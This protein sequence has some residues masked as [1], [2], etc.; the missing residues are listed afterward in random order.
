MAQNKKNHHDDEGMS[1]FSFSNSDVFND[2]EPQQYQQDQQHQ[3]PRQDIRLGSMSSDNSSNYSSVPVSVSQYSPQ[4]TPYNSVFHT[5][6]PSNDFKGF[7]PPVPP[8][9]LEKQP[10]DSYMS[11]F[12]Q[13]SDK[14]NNEVAEQV[15][16][17]AVNKEENPAVKYNDN[18]NQTSPKQYISQSHSPSQTNYYHEHKGSL[19]EQPDTDE[20]ESVFSKDGSIKL[21]KL[22]TQAPNLNKA[23][24]PTLSYQTNVEGSVPPRSTRRPRS[25]IVVT[26]NELAKDIDNFKKNRHSKRHSKRFSLSISDDLDKLMESANSISFNSDNS[27]NERNN[28]KDLHSINKGKQSINEDENDDEKTK[29]NKTLLSSNSSSKNI[30][31]L[32]DKQSIDKR[33]DISTIQENSDTEQI[34]SINKKSLDSLNS[35]APYLSKRTEV[36]SDQSSD[37]Y[38]TADNENMTSRASES[39]DS[40]A[41]TNTNI[42][43][44]TNSRSRP[45]L[46]PRPSFDNIQKARKLSNQVQAK[47]Q[48]S[49]T[50]SFES[51]GSISRSSSLNYHETSQDSPRTLILPKREDS[52]ISSNKDKFVDPDVTISQPQSRVVSQPQIFDSTEVEPNQINESELRNINET[53]SKN[54]QSQFELDRLNKRTSTQFATTAPLLEENEN[55][56]EN[57]QEEE[58]EE[59]QGADSNKKT[60]TIDEN[61][62]EGNTVD[63]NVVDEKEIIDELKDQSF[64]HPTQSS[65]QAGPTA[66]GDP[67]DEYYDIGS[68]IIVKQPSRGKLVKESTRHHKKNKPKRAKSKRI[69]RDSANSHNHNTVATGANLKP[70]SYHTLINLLESINGTIIGEEFNQLNLPVKEKQLIEKIVDSLSRLTS[71][72]II[73]ENRYDIGI[74]RL[75]KTLRVLEGFM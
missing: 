26:G 51:Y 11:G 18:I 32:P 65:E 12:S 37:T 47:H 36:N 62:V 60:I 17:K 25:E 48:H 52:L 66:G 15:S 2:E 53:E 61:T 57:V 43:T 10:R 9:A 34:T 3:I 74:D 56:E 41:S 14:Y 54:E 68:P 24:Q 71:D 1:E 19:V 29:E 16:I 4:R 35:Q 44:R 49:R 20:T 33:N 45:D 7:Q 30:S 55:I 21:G 39:G 75:E 8:A 38:E 46:P 73:D 50:S 28:N 42:N 64:T 23:T 5:P 59:E 70:F 69:K 40:I 6:Q 31:S 67:D 72:M 58:Q 27:S 13:F 63:E 22:T